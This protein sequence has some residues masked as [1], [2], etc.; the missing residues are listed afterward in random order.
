VKGKNQV[1]VEI[2]NHFVHPQIIYEKTS[3]DLR[4]SFQ[5]DHA[6]TDPI[7]SWC[8]YWLCG[9]IAAV[10]YASGQVRD[11]LFPGWFYCGSSVLVQLGTIIIL[12]TLI[13]GTTGIRPKL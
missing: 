4:N 5:W 1:L 9:R 3:F 6:R 10:L 13:G 2:Q 8:P 12:G 7:P 11:L